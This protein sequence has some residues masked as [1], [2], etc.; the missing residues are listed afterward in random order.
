MKLK[1]CLSVIASTLEDVV[2]SRKHIARV[3]V[4]C[5]GLINSLY[6]SNYSADQLQ[7]TQ[8]Q[9]EDLIKEMHEVKC[10]IQETLSKANTEI[11]NALNLQEVASIEEVLQILGTR[12]VKAGPPPGENITPSE[13]LNLLRL[14]YIYLTMLKQC[15]VDKMSLEIDKLATMAAP[16]IDAQSLRVTVHTLAS[17]VALQDDLEACQ[18]ELEELKN[19]L[20]LHNIL[21]EED[22]K[23]ISE[24]I[25]DLLYLTKEKIKLSSIIVE[26]ENR[27]SQ[28]A[29]E[30]ESEERKKKA[31]QLRLDLVI[32]NGFCPID[33]RNRVGDL[34]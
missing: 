14:K 23:E 13:V 34:E 2:S 27:Y 19:T 31:R 16:L 1:T 28:I 18:L 4:L 11:K 6:S 15:D 22:R 30:E 8:K 29:S 3:E 5:K 33:L 26:M 17:R 20:P 12:L 7:K 21:P 25:D 9:I 24:E 10:T 32:L